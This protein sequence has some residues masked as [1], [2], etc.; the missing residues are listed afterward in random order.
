M[1]RCTSALLQRTFSVQPVTRYRCRTYTVLAQ[2]IEQ[3]KTR[4]E[5]FPLQHEPLVKSR[6]DPYT[7][8]APELLHLR[9]S[10]L[11]LLGSAH[12]GLSEIARYYFLHPSKQLRSLVVLLF[13][14]ATN[15]LGG[16]WEQKRWGAERE[17]ST[18]L[19]EELDRPLTLPDV[20][21]NWHPSMPNDT[22]S[23]ETPFDLRP[24]GMHRVPDSPPP[25]A[26]RNQSL[27]QLTS[28]PLLL[29]VQ[30]RLAQIMEMIHIASLL[31][32]DVIDSCTFEAEPPE[33][34][35]NKL[36]I[37]G[38]DFLLGRASAALSRLGESEV[39][40]LV[41]GVISNLVEGEMMRMK[42][43]RTP[44]LGQLEGPQSLEEAWSAYLKKT[45][46]KTASLLAKSARAAVVLGGCREGEIWK[47][48]A[49]AYGRNIGIA[50]Q[51]VEDTL[52][53]EAG[54]TNPMPGLA[55]GPAIYASEEH[56]ELLQLMRRNFGDQ[57]DVELAIDYVRR[58]SGV[59]RTRL[60][61]RTY[62]NKARD[63][64]RSLP[65]SD[66]KIALDV[67][68]DHVVNRTW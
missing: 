29:P 2:R 53:Y 60:L 23:F 15:G 5:P 57:G 65:D 32:D 67:L 18:G 14:R 19:S 56:S 46:L 17:A 42:C 6:P 7:I 48:V 63:V 49:Y 43:V 30:I 13:S 68:T 66:T 24:P 11:G 25:P 27:P 59:E 9:G 52:D 21:N 38:G 22:A 26:T 4:P 16:N 10:L 58:S 51:L 50:Y 61:A 64:L 62:A 36:S 35:G 8:V 39:V 1:K 33:G 12:P 28:P 34:F 45:Y 55:T 3:I 31:H 44:G 54:S 20:L 40:E 47:D 41:A 37:L